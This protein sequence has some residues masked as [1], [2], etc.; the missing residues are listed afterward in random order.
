MTLI[1]TTD[2]LDGQGGGRGVRAGPR[3]GLAPMDIPQ[4]RGGGTHLGVGTAGP[5]PSAIAAAG[6]VIVA[7]VPCP[8][9]HIPHTH[10]RATGQAGSQVGRVGLLLAGSSLH[11]ARVPSRTAV[12][13]V[14]TAH[15]LGGTGWRSPLSFPGG[16]GWGGNSA[17][18]SREAG[19]HS[20]EATG[21][22]PSPHSGWGSRSAPRGSWCAGHSLC[23]CGETGKP[24]GQV[25]SPVQ[26]PSC[27]PSDNAL[28][29]STCSHGD[30]SAHGLS[31][32][33]PAGGS[34]GWSGKLLCGTEKLSPCLPRLSLPLTAPPAGNEPDR[35]GGPPVGQRTE[36][37]S[38]RSLTTC[39]GQDTVATPPQCSPPT[40]A[41][42]GQDSS[43]TP[44]TRVDSRYWKRDS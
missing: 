33:Q 38:N 24:G 36:E 27:P 30:S 15:S 41:P 16:G 7:K 8:T 31:S 40:Y 20:R 1:G 29:P 2:A 26:S 32:R 23:L 18:L 37:Q 21:S 12:L 14:L 5:A 34:T 11:V 22:R 6:L 25:S 10:A 35:T 3:Q 42:L 44:R 17:P 19:G 9:L 28:R 13:A 43:P 4:P 39:P